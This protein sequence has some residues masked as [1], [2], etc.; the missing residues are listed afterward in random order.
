MIGSGKYEN[1]RIIKLRKRDLESEGNEN[2]RIIKL[3]KTYLK[4][5]G[6]TLPHPQHH[7]LT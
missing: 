7:P 4:S 5:G 6:K 2:T 3:I 1:T